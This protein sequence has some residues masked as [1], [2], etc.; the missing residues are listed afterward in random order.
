MIVSDEFMAEKLFWLQRWSEA[1]AARNWNTVVTRWL[2]THGHGPFCQD[3]RIKL[4]QLY[5]ECLIRG[6]D[7][8][9][10][11]EYQRIKSE[12]FLLEA[13][14]GNA[15]CT[16]HK[17]CSDRRSWLQTGTGIVLPDPYLLTIHH[18]QLCCT[19]CTA[20]QDYKMAAAIQMTSSVLRDI[21]RFEVAWNRRLGPLKMGPIGSPET[22]VLNHLMPHNKSEDG[23]IHLV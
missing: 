9:K 4:I 18:R 23:R 3:D 2:I 12:L 13:H 16:N 1:L 17:L 7:S 11:L 14:I 8:G 10:A 15:E 19:N 5:D 6:G 22:S 20:E 21:T